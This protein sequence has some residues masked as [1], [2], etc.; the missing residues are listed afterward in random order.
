[1]LAGGISPGLQAPTEEITQL[2][3][4]FQAQAQTQANATFETFEVIGYSTQVVAGTNYYIRVRTGA[5]TYTDLRVY[6]PLPGQGE[7]E[8]SS[9]K[10]GVAKDAAFTF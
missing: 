9:V 5:D 1:M 10:V 3:E 8:L 4:T 7:M 2:A 6:E